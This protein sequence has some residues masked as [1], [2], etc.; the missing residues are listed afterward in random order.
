MNPP[1]EPTVQ[2]NPTPELR[3]QAI[4]PTEPPV[5]AIRSKRR[6]V[7]I[8]VYTVGLAL[9][10]YGTLLFLLGMGV[11]HQHHPQRDDYYLQ[12]GSVTSILLVI[13][14]AICFM[15]G[16]FLTRLKLS[17]KAV[18]SL[19]GVVVYVLLLKGVAMVTVLNPK[20]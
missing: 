5:Q 13:G 1:P 7:A 2:A 9:G 19:V 16:P 14:G 15:V 17:W 20:T 11:A 8:C 4:P 12:E 10:V 3:V 18:A 6:F